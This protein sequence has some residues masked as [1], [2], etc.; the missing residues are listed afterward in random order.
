MRLRG[1]FVA[2]LSATLFANILTNVF[3]NPGLVLGVLAVR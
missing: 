1:V 2:E 3:V